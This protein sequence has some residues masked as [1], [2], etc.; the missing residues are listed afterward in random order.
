MRMG[1]AGSEE[2]FNWNVPTGDFYAAFKE[3]GSKFHFSSQAQCP[4]RSWF[5]SELSQSSPRKDSGFARLRAKAY[6]EHSDG[7]A[8]STFRE[9]EMVC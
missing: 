8:A 6:L 2:C 5:F 1:D 3:N 7:C 9:C 4:G